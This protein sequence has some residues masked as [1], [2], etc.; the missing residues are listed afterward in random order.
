[1]PYT[2]DQYYKLCEAISLGATTV[3][4]SDKEV[5]YRSLSDMLKLKE[6]MESELFPTETK[7]ASLN[8]RKYV[9]FN[10]GFYPNG[11]EGSEHN[12]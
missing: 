3:K 1:M 10:R 11:I 12:R 6:L 9:D 8:R 2:S 7:K 4:Y 5:G